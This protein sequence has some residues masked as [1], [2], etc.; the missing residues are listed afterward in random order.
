MAKRKHYFVTIEIEVDVENPR[1]TQT[2]SNKLRQYINN[3]LKREGWD[4]DFFVQHDNVVSIFD[5]RGKQL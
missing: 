3:G 4:Y 5:E 2:A 1:D